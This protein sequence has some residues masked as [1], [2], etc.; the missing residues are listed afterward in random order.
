MV[1]MSGN[2]NETISEDDAISLMIEEPETATQDA[3]DVANEAE[4]EDAETDELEAQ[5]GETDDADEA[6]ADADDDEYE[7]NDEAEEAEDDPV[8]EIDTVHGKQEVA[9][10]EL[11]AGYMRQA[12]YTKKTMEA[13]EIRK[14][15]E[16][17]KTELAQ[18][19]QQLMEAL[20]YWAV[21]TEQ[22]P[23]WA[24]IA[25]ER[26]PQEV[27]ALQQQW[28]Q[29][30]QQKQQ[31]AQYHQQLQAQEKAELMAAEQERLYEAFPEW[32]DPAKFQAGAQAMVN[33]GGNYGFSAEEMA[34]MV[35]HRMFKVLS[36]AMKYRD[37]QATKP[38][39]TK[40]VAKAP[41]KLKS[42]AKPHKAQ[43]DKVARQKQLDR[44]K[45]TGS[46]DD[47]VSLLLGGG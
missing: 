27:F 17:V 28:N 21:P 37:L 42:G 6:D 38:K 45:K 13:S 9:L 5:E 15:A 23:N 11:T 24:Q 10:S 26:T 25:Q 22:E 18:N 14:E 47:A 2:L 31:A 8:F 33:A 46:T 12:D 4:T 1:Q 35:D 36:D 40:K 16:A 7:D 43:A 34:G 20:S 30:Q 41:R 3:D 29:R 19:K 32:R 44:L 39:V